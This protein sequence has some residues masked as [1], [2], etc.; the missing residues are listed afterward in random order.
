MRQPCA[1]DTTDKA[2]NKTADKA[3]DSAV[4]SAA[5][6]LDNTPEPRLGVDFGRVIQGGA[7]PDGT[8]DTVFLEGGLEEALST[9]ASE[10][11]FEVLPR[12]VTRF[13][14]RVWVIS[15][16]RPSIQ[17][18]TLRWLNRHDFFARTGIARDNVRFCRRRADK[19]VHCRELAI[20]HMIDDR[21][22]V[23]EALRGLVPNLYLFGPQSA[24]PPDWVVPVRTWAEVEEA[25]GTA[26]HQR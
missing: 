25:I 4:D 15:K 20:T 11:M 8:E 21:L 26:T 18:R 2:A 9:P 6:A 5:G 10:G 7:L 3:I 14:G 13:G 24:P 1:V 23:H 22:D 19:A 16:C 17:R 12:L